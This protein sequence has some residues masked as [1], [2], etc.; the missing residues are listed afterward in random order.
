MSAKKHIFVHVEVLQNG[1]PLDSFRQKINHNGLISLGRT[2]P[3]KLRMPFYPLLGRTKILR[4]RK[5]A[6]HLRLDSSWEGFVSAKGELSKISRTTTHDTRFALKEGDYAS[7]AKGDLRILIKVAPAVAEAPIDVKEKFRG[8]LWRLFLGTKTEIYGLAGGTFCALVVF[9]ALIF[10][11]LQ[12]ADDRP[13]TLQDLDASYVLGMINPLHLGLLPETLQDRLARN[14][15][16][17]LAIEYYGELATLVSTGDDKDYN[18]LLPS[19]V[20]RMQRLHAVFQERLEQYVDK[21]LEDEK[22][23]LAINGQA[24]LKIPAAL[25]ESFDATLVRLEKNIEV[26]HKSQDAFLRLRREATKS[27]KEDHLYDYNEYKNVKSGETSKTNEEL[28]KIRVFG[29]LSD[30]EAM[31]FEADQWKQRA[32]RAQRRVKAQRQSF[33]PMTNELARPIAFKDDS[34]LAQ[35]LTADDLAKLNK[36]L[37]LIQPAQFGVSRVEQRPEVKEPLLGELDP[38]LIEKIISKNRFEL[39]LCFELALRRNHNMSGTMKWQWR[40]DSRGKI[41]DL[42]LVSSNIID[43]QMKNCVMKKISSWRFPRPKRGSVEITYPFHFKPAK[44]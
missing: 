3:N 29:Q 27:F 34:G 15:T 5:Q 35:F 26:A 32:E 41:S 4:I 13:K 22:R 6:A 17:N 7:L 14:Q 2:W 33:S 40:L 31:Y 1:E 12:R 38:R 44:G 42:T 37:S 20:E 11:L 24:V 8:S 9:G 25:G 23:I 28:N 21:L 36:K 18:L 43:R 19:T 16:L 39:Q 10:G 30:E